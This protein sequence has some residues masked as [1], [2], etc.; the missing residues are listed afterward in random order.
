LPNRDEPAA[1]SL[2]GYCRQVQAALS[3]EQ[4]QHPPSMRPEV[5]QAAAWRSFHAALLGAAK[6]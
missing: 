6:N 3:A 5:K 2:S 4:P 1:Q